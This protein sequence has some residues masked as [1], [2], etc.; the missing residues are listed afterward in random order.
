MEALYRDESPR[1]TEI[2]E[3]EMEPIDKTLRLEKKNN[4]NVKIQIGASLI[5][6]A[7]TG[8]IAAQDIPEG[9]QFQ[10]EGIWIPIEEDDSCNIS[11]YRWTLF[12]YD[13]ETGERN[14]DTEVLG[15]IDACSLE[16]S[17]WTRYVNCSNGED[18]ANL[19][20][21]QEYNRIYYGTKRD[22]KEGEELY[23]W[24]GRAFAKALGIVK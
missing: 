11:E 10:Y 15:I 17:N 19:V 16:K 5:Q 18:K 8:V 9:Y 21:L 13:Q 2:I 4:I 14:S 6:G 24:Y 12:Q 23:V 7:G 22:I 1:E 3:I 20:Q